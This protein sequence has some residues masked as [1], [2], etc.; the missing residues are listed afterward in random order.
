MHI[1]I[2]TYGG[3]L[4]SRIHSRQ[5]IMYMADAVSAGLMW[6]FWFKIKSAKLKMAVIRRALRKYICMY[7]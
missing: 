2:Y 1:H 7:M 5:C 3:G 4:H 6:Q